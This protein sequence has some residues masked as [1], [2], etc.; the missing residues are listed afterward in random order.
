MREPAGFLRVFVVLRLFE[1]ALLFERLQF[2]VHAF[3]PLLQC[4]NH[5][6]LLTELL[7]LLVEL[8]I[9][10]ALFSQL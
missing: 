6:L 5:P 9:P 4:F 3:K 2:V 1:N 10:V 8:L 7:L